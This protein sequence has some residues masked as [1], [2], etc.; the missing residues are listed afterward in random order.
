MI[1]KKQWT[2]YIKDISYAKMA[3]KKI[4]LKEAL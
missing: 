4:K 3:G 1:T 2:K